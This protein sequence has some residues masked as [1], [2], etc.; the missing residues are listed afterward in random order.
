MFLY[1]KIGTA[2]FEAHTHTHV[3]TEARGFYILQVLLLRKNQKRN[4]LRKDN[5]SINTG[6]NF[7]RTLMV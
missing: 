4:G 1:H 3:C 7:Y 6:I 5:F 2:L